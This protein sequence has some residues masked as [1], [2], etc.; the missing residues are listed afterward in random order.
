MTVRLYQSTDSSAPS[1]TGAVG[2]LVALLD[3]VLVNGYGAKSAA[4]WTKP[5]TST[6]QAV[7][8]MTTSSATGFYLNVNDNGP[9]AGGAK[10]ARMTGFQTASAVATGTG[11]FPTLSQLGIGIGAVVCRKSTTADST[12]R[13]WTM[14][15][16][17]TCFYLFVETGDQTAPV[18]CMSF[19]FGDFFSYSS[20][21]TSY[22]AIIGRTI[23]N[24]GAAGTAS[25][26]A[27]LANWYES[28]TTLVTVNTTTLSNTLP[29]HYIAANFTG[30]GGSLAFGKCTDQTLM[31]SASTSAIAL[32]LG[33]AG[34]VSTGT[35]GTGT[36]WIG[37]FNYPNPPDNGLYTAPVRIVHTQS[38][39]GYF[40]GLWAPLQHLP[41]NHLDTYSGTG[42]MAGKS[43]IAI[44]IFG[45]SSWANVNPPTPAAC[46]VHVEYSD[47]WS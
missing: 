44:S 35:I 41:I 8:R 20:T 10:E 7:F 45:G 3:A 36:T 23:E 32:Q 15:A 38:V 30:V 2:S 27:T 46:Q 26:G 18:M 21:D 24:N 25:P 33:Y 37:Q 29:G 17:A 31:G 4:G 12:A 42:N 6:N 47:T 13:A 28:F 34:Y 11:Q 5:Y 9:G 22:C 16:D 40:K 14:V 19:M 1:L 43:L 39:R